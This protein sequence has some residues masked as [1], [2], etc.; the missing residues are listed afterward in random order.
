ML[1]IRK[2][3][4]LDKHKLLQL[5]GATAEC[6]FN[7]VEQN[8]MLGAARNALSNETIN[9]FR[10]ADVFMLWGRRSSFWMVSYKSHFKKFEEIGMNVTF[11]VG[12]NTVG[13]LDMGGASTQIASASPNEILEGAASTVVN[14]VAFRLFTRSF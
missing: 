6:V 3:I 7:V 9:P 14:G 10:P 1:K 11:L 8:A 12:S 4:S 13:I 2:Y 5:V